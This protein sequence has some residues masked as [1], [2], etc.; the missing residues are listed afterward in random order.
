MTPFFIRVLGTLHG[1]FGL[2]IIVASYSALSQ[3]ALAKLSTTQ[4]AIKLGGT[5]IGALAL[6]LCMLSAWLLSPQSYL[7]A[8]AALV[9]FALTAF[10]DTVALRGPSGFFRLMPAFYVAFAIRAGAAL[11]LTVLV[12]SLPGASASG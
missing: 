6:L 4:A 7:L 11:L 8:W 2:W 10:S 9:M 3:G 12:R 1:L 5:A